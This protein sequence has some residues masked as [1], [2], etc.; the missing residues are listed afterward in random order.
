ML[1]PLDTRG[2]DRCRGLA[3]HKTFFFPLRFRSN[4]RINSNLLTVLL[5]SHVGSPRQIRLLTPAK[6][7][8]LWR[9]RAVPR[10]RLFAFILIG[11]SKKPETSP[12]AW[13]KVRIS[14][15]S[16]TERIKLGE[17]ATSEEF[18]RRRT[19]ATSR[20]PSSCI[21]VR[22]KSNRW[23]TK[24]EREER[25]SGGTRGSSCLGTFLISWQAGI[26]TARPSSPL[27]F[28]LWTLEDARG[29]NK[30]LPLL[31]FYFAVELNFGGDC[32]TK[33]LFFSDKFHCFR[34][35]VQDTKTTFEFVLTLIEVPLILS[36]PRDYVYIFLIF[37]DFCFS[38]LFYFSLH[39]NPW[40]EKPNATQCHSI[41][42]IE[43]ST[44]EAYY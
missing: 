15:G 41:F 4:E 27:R 14:R 25:S 34:T 2:S 26:K 35:W 33:I 10:L 22:V 40:I 8:P 39:G 17:R 13:K 6:T 44:D 24:E 38:F 28:E 29:G 32:S 31:Y 42:T 18:E 20:C 9:R 37:L 36:L 23:G 19:D 30:N 7:R 3:G 16:F 1:E 21:F 43:L 5:V 11:E 12:A